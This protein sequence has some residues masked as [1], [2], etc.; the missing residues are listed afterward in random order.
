MGDGQLNEQNSNEQNYVK[1]PFLKRALD[2]FGYMFALNV[3]FVVG[4]LPIFTI[5]ASLTALYAMCIRIQEGQEETVIAGFIYEFKRSFKQATQAFFL[6]VAILVFMFFQFIYINNYSGTLA[7]FYSGFLIVECVALAIVSVFLFPLIARFE[8]T[9]WNTIKNSAVLSIT[10][11]GT[12]IKI[13][14]AW[15]APIAF[16]IIY[17]FLFMNL[18]YL[19]LLLLFGMIAWGCSKSFRRLFKKNSSRMEEARMAKEAAIQKNNEK[20]T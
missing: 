3:C 17:P 9:L 4:C 13:A 1:E 20:N 16:C 5:G 12:W 19:W 11:L 15:V 10:Y 2:A 8:N 7:T 6:I 18:W 14:T